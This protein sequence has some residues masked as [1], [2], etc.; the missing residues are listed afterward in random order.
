MLTGFKYF[1]M[2]FDEVI[3]LYAGFDDYFKKHPDEKESEFFKNR[4][5]KKHTKNRE[6]FVGKKTAAFDEFLKALSVEVDSSA[7]EWEYFYQFAD[8][9]NICMFSNGTYS[10]YFD[11]F[12]D[13]SLQIEVVKIAVEYPKHN[14]QQ[15]VTLI[16][17]LLKFNRYCTGEIYN[18]SEKEFVKEHNDEIKKHKKQCLYYKK[19]NITYRIRKSLKLKEKSF[20]YDLKPIT[21]W[22]SVILAIVSVFLI[23]FKS[24]NYVNDR[25]A[26]VGTESMFWNGKNYSTVNGEYKEGK[27]IAKSR[28]GAWSINEVK[29]DP[30]HNFVVAR[31][32]TT[33]FLYVADDYQ[34][35]ESGKLTKVCIGR[36]YVDDKELLAVLSR[37]DEL[38]TTT[39]DY[40]T[41]DI[42]MQ[43]DTQCM[44][45]LYFAYQCCPIATVN[46]GY[47]GK[48][49]GKWVVTTYVSDDGRAVG[50]YSV[51]DD[52]A[53]VLEKYYDKLL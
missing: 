20:K 4:Q 42:L 51:P 14:E 3:D 9:G 15:I 35:L 16:N 39:F 46:K 33:Q 22:C 1:Y 12:L 53:K 23:L 5:N 27:T 31:A 18:S 48:I 32:F 24:C 49:D 47:I 37:I 29:G 38:K 28:D 6:M 44:K 25:S 8:G 43:T 19:R 13:P 11:L 2:D 36:E 34:I 40:V 50:C 41:E 17:D 10:L 21:R 52:C 7:I 45:K 30:S 26:S